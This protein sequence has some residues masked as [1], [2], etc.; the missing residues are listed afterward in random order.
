M[1]PITGLL[2]GH[3]A[4][5][6][7][8]R[9]RRDRHDPAGQTSQIHRNPRTTLDGA[10]TLEQEQAQLFASTA[11]ARKAEPVAAQQPSRGQRR[12]D[13][14][15]LAAAALLAPWPLALP[16]RDASQLEEADEPSP[17]AAAA[18]DGEGGHA[19]L[20]RPGEQSAIA[21]L[22]CCDLAAAELRAEPIES[23]R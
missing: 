12:V 5:S 8:P 22:G 21:G 19:E 7:R 1:S 15:A 17:V 9:L 16:D 2:P 14:V 20:Q 18:L 23:N 10:S 13:H 4:E 11:T 3:P 6:L